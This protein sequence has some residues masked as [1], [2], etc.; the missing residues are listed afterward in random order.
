MVLEVNLNNFVAEAEHNGMLCPHPLLHVDAAW[1][2]L[3]LVSLIKKVSLDQLLLL[4]WIVVLLQVGLE[5]LKKGNFLL[6]LLWEVREIVL[7]HNILLF[8]GGNCLSLIVV[9]LRSTGLGY[10]FGGIIKENSCRHIRE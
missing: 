3:K 2:I 5:V 8:V 6:Q 9:E 1:W 10:D 7:G 4:L